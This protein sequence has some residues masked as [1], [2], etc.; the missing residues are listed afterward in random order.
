ML[1]LHSCERLLWYGT[2]HELDLCLKGRKVNGHAFAYDS[3]VRIF[4]VRPNRLWLLDNWWLCG[5][6]GIDGNSTRRSLTLGCARVTEGRGQ[7]FSWELNRNRGLRIDYR[8]RTG[9]FLDKFL[10]G[11]KR[12]RGDGR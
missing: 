11:R 10:F 7:G 12:L 4:S 5:N 9:G 6:A 2:F 3:V 1:H 8:L